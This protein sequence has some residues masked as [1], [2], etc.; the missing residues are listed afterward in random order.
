MSKNYNKNIKCKNYRCFTVTSLRPLGEEWNNCNSGAEAMFS[1]TLG[2]GRKIK[3]RIEI[4]WANVWESMNFTFYIGNDRIPVGTTPGSHTE[5]VNEVVSKI[6]RNK[7][8][9]GYCMH[10]LVSQLSSYTSFKVREHF[11]SPIIS[12]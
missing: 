11:K 12:F 2:N 5:N 10:D 1:A 8:I 9:T 6:A 3:G 7:S 4:S